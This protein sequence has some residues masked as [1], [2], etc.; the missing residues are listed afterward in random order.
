[1]RRLQ[2]WVRASIGATGFGLSVAWYVLLR[3]VPLSNATRRQSFA[4]MMSRLTCRPLGIRIRTIGCERIGAHHPCVYVLNHQSQ[5]DYPISAS[6]FPGSAV[7]MASQIGDW[8]VM[9][10]LYRS[11]GCIALDR[12]VPIRAAAALAEAEQ[13]VREKNLSVWIFAEGT[14][15][16]QPGTMGKFRRGAFRLAAATGV[17]VVPIVLS[18]LKPY[19]DLR[20]RRLSSHTVTMTV[21]DPVYANGSTDADEEAL[22]DAVRSRMLATLIATAE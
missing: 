13:A 18:P 5:L 8:P 10:A 17:P 19:S 16:K 6:I 3:L 11:S 1:M 2:F 20:G 12:D 14:R 4:R 9:G 15:G 21:L 7:V 22:S